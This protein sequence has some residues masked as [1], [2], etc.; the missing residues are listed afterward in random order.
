MKVQIWPKD[1]SLPIPDLV[2][3]I[4]EN[5]V[6]FLFSTLNTAQ[7]TSKHQMGGFI[8][9]LTNSSTP[10]GCPTINSVLTLSTWN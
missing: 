6:F 7:N 2:G 3:Y 4:G 8:P 1:H 5:S 10:S 9:T